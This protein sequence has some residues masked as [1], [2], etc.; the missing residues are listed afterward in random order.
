MSRSEP[1]PASAAPRQ[2][3]GTPNEAADDAANGTPPAV[4]RPTGHSALRRVRAWHVWGAAGA[5]CAVGAAV[6]GGLGVTQLGGPALDSPVSIEVGSGLADQLTQANVDQ[7]LAASPVMASQP[8]RFKVMSGEPSEEQ[9]NRLFTDADFY[10]FWRE[11]DAEEPV[12]ILARSGLDTST[13]VAGVSAEGTATINR[14][15]GQGP[16]SLTFALQHG[17]VEAARRD[18]ASTTSLTAAGGLGLAA[19][20]LAGITVGAR[21]RHDGP[22]PELGAVAE[23]A[24]LSTLDDPAALRPVLVELLLRASTALA[25]DPPDDGAAAARARDLAELAQAAPDGE[26]PVPPHAV[27]SLTASVVARF[28]TRSEISAETEG[29]VDASE[30]TDADGS[31]AAAVPRTAPL[32][33]AAVA[34]DRALNQALV[35]PAGPGAIT[36]ATTKTTTKTPITRPA[37]GARLRA[38]S[39]GARAGR[40]TGALAWRGAVCAGVS[41][42]AVLL[43][44]TPV[45]RAFLPQQPPS[46]A[47]LSAQL[48][49]P[50]SAAL[51][52]QMQPDIDAVRTSGKLHLR[53][54]AVDAPAELVAARAKDPGSAV[55][56]LSPQ[57]TQRVVDAAAAGA[58]PDA[59]PQWASPSVA[60]GL[61]QA[62]S[63]DT[64]RS[65]VV[66]HTRLANGDSVLLG[67]RSSTPSGASRFAWGP[68][69]PDSDQLSVVPAK[70]AP[71]EL[72]NA[73]DKAAFAAGDDVRKP[74]IVSVNES[75]WIAGVAGGLGT[76]AVLAWVWALRRARRSRGAG[77]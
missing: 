76:A 46:V 60:S 31:A 69:L 10:V 28:G 65:I 42:A 17:V 22:A 55:L 73:L 12:E 23:R 19:V 34:L 3:E 39:L 26:Q 58:G 14:R 71:A 41:V 2:P 13:R 56:A 29:I 4:K 57:V 1:H 21:R 47:P 61:N 20:T 63:P 72:A 30:T 18:D 50:G 25:T 53:L 45:F 16:A 64:E 36:K 66:V 52:D 51:Q 74:A 49:G 44:T 62:A 43:G 9:Q 59:A 6:F 77:S 11:R 70:D 8:L 37:P 35:A 54:V 38:T 24:R 68:A 75:A 5:L 48:S 32:T 7:I 67:S 33:A 15:L 27:D 40:G